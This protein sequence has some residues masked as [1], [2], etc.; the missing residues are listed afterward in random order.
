MF[1]QLCYVQI[2]QKG[3]RGVREAPGVKRENAHHLRANRA[4]NLAITGPPS[5]FCKTID[6][7]LKT[8]VTIAIFSLDPSTFQPAS[9]AMNYAP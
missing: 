5:L 9:E 8:F 1:Y 7:F 3:H 6:V 4:E 2:L